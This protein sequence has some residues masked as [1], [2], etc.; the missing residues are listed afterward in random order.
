[1]VQVQTNEISIEVE[2]FGLDTWSWSKAE[3]HLLP[4]G[5]TI[6][7]LPFNRCPPF[8]VESAVVDVGFGTPREVEEKR[9][10]LAGSVALMSNRDLCEPGS[11][12]VLFTGRSHRQRQ[13]LPAGGRLA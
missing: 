5:L 1:M 10:Q 4:S 2:E 9:S 13:R 11:R 8:T 12:G 3:A 6:Q 7:I